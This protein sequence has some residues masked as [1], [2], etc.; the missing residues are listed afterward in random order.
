ME[1]VFLLLMQ[2]FMITFIEAIFYTK[3]Q[4]SSLQCTQHS[5]CSERDRARWLERRRLYQILFTLRNEPFTQIIY[6]H[7]FVLKFS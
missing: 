2:C 1:M 7:L 4:I 3:G 5:F 6:C